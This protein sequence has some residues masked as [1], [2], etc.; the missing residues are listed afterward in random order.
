MHWGWTIQE[1]DNT[2]QEFGG[3]P[4]YITYW[5]VS[6]SGSDIKGFATKNRAR[7][8][9]RKHYKE[10]RAMEDPSAGQKL[11]EDCGLVWDDLDDFEKKSWTAM[12]AKHGAHQEE[13]EVDF[14]DDPELSG[15]DTPPKNNSESP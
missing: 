5:I 7:F 15:S 14:Y 1:V 13:D 9:W 2:N 3:V 10:L 6:P 4:G 12:A 11:A 8:Y